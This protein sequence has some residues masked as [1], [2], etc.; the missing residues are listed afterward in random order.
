MKT[1]LPA[2]V[3]TTTVLATACL[4]ADTQGP[5][6]GTC[7]ATPPAVEGLV[8]A[9]SGATLALASAIADTF[10]TRHPATRVTVAAS[11]GTGGAV[12]ALL[13]GAID[14]GLASREL[15]EAER[16]SGLHRVPLGRI[17]LGIVVGRDRI[18]RGLTT[19]E[20][21]ALLGGHRRT[22]DDGTPVVV[23][24]RERGDGGNRLL[25]AYAPELG[26]A[27][28]EALDSRRWPTAYTDQ[29]MVETLLEVPGAVGL[30]DIGT[31]R[32]RKLPLKALA[33]DGVRPVD[34][35]AY[36]LLKPVS[37]LVRSDADPAVKEFVVTATSGAVAGH[38]VRGGYLH[39]AGRR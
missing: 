12:A 14:I 35:E 8:V 29:E 2:V 25:R 24:M 6:A 21:A 39:P 15:S 9:G 3:A 26:Q 33:L 20:V 23:V 27:L 5:P 17:A 28:D 30:L 31:L 34:R 10:E 19:P 36:P 22:W 7:A 32:L 13:D 38:L 4:G 11:I 18:E 16:G 37:L 1:C